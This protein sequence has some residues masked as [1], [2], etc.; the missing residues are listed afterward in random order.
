MNPN[1]PGQIISPGQPQE[2]QAP[3]PTPELPSVPPAQAPTQPSQPVSGQPRAAAPQ[4]MASQG[5]SPAQPAKPASGLGVLRSKLKLIL[6]GLGGL[7]ILIVALVVLLDV[8][9]HHKPKKIA[10]TPPPQK[11]LCYVRLDYLDCAN[12][13]N[14]NAKIVRYNLPSLPQSA[15]ITSLVANANQPGYLAVSP[16]SQGTNN[17]WIIKSNMQLDQQ[18]LLPSGETGAA[19][20][21]SHDGKSILLEVDG[22]DGSRQIERYTIATQQLQPLTNSGY[23][24]DPYETTDGHIIYYHSDDGTTNWQVY[25][26]NNDGSQPQPLGNLT[27]LSSQEGLS[28]D[29]A[30]D[31]I[32]VFGV[33][34]NNQPL[35][36][37]G[38]TS[39]FLQARYVQVLQAP[40]DGPQDQ[41]GFVNSN[42]VV[43]TN[44]R[45]AYLLNLASH[46]QSA[47]ISN[48]GNLVGMLN[49]SQFQ[50]SAQQ[51]EQPDERIIG[52]SAAPQDFQTYIEQLFATGDQSCS[53]VVA[54][55]K[56][57]IQYEMVINQVVS[58][59]Y[60]SVTEGCGALST[61]YYY[62]NSGGVWVSAFTESST[63]PTCAQLTQYNNFTGQIIS[64]CYNTKN[65]LVPNPNP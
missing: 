51:Q 57:S 61:V 53:Q 20:S 45:L 46:A 56:A 26:M 52:L 49:T 63:P 41:V 62:K 54:N 1:S 25:V 23:N 18:V 50:K 47:I 32:F 22:T 31:M 42:T 13:N 48:F 11:Q 7:V 40:V 29:P 17:I 12:V 30:Q 14:L 60:A 44:G 21:W 43:L 38:T 3:G 37:Y 35:I 27:S 64:Q 10:Y 24:T 59:N 34:A 39:A 19:P 2:P 28:Y 16:T 55:Q 6:L 36:V 33:G 15:R 8:L 5:V 9:G 65:A 58:D 4:I